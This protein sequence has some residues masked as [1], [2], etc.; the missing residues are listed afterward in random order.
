[1]TTNLLGLAVGTWKISFNDYDY[2][3]DF[4]CRSYDQ[5]F[6][7]HKIDKFQNIRSI[8]MVETNNMFHIIIFDQWLQ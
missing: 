5:G 2:I 3:D 1:M 6:Y 8:T 4:S 7:A